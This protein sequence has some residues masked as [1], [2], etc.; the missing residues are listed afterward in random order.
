MWTA[1][2]NRRQN[3]KL[4]RYIQ[5][6]RFSDSSATMEGIEYIEDRYLDKGKMLRFATCGY[7]VEGRHII[8]KGGVRQR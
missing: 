2:W 4:L 3:N 1:E 8:L 5:N 6:A 7:A